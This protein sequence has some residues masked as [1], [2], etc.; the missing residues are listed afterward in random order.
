[1][2]FILNICPNSSCKCLAAWLPFCS[3]SS[4]TLLISE[5]YLKGVGSLDGEKSMHRFT[6]L[7][8]L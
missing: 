5:K 8:K 2:S 4:S 6:W 1:M 7:R 3:G